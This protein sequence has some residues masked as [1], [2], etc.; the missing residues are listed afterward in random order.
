MDAKVVSV[1]TKTVQAVQLATVNLALLKIEAGAAAVAQAAEA[2][3]LTLT[4]LAAAALTGQITLLTA[5]EKA[6]TIVTNKASAALAKLNITITATTLGIA[7]VGAALIVGALAFKNYVDNMETAAEADPWTKKY[8]EQTRA[9]RD[10][11]SALEELKAAREESNKTDNSEIDNIQRLWSELQ[12]YVDETGNVIAE[13]ERAAEIIELLNKNY[14]M[15]IDYIDGQ[16]QGYQD[17]SSSMDDYIA[18]LRLESQIRNGQDAYDEAVSNYQEYVKK[19]EAL[20]DELDLKEKAFTKAREDGNTEVAMVFGEQANSLKQAIGALDE[21]IDEY[22]EEMSEYESLF[23][24]QMTS[25]GSNPLVDFVSGQMSSASKLYADGMQTIASAQEA[26]TTALSD[27]WKRLEHDFAT[28]AIATESELWA[29]KSALLDKYGNADLED[30]WRYYEELYS[31]QQDYA[32]ESVRLA[33]K[34]AEEQREAAEKAA[35]EQVAAR[36]SEWENIERLNSLGLMNDK[37]AA[38]AR[39]DFVKKYYGDADLTTGKGITDENYQY[40]KKVYDD[41]IDMTKQSI[42]EQE[43]IVDDGL[44]AIIKRYRQAYDDLEQK[45]KAYRD[46]LMAMGGDLFSVEEI[47]NPDGSKKKQYTVNNVD[48]QLRKMREYHAS[49]KKLRADGM[50]DLMLSDLTSMNDEDSMQFAKYLSGMSASEFAKIN[51]L[52]NEKQKLADELANDLYK[53]DAQM[54][55]DSMTDALGDLATSAYAY[56]AQAAEE[57]SNGRHAKDILQSIGQ[58][59]RHRYYSCI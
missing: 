9:I 55:S 7:A 59:K 57:F 35:E 39:A 53:N 37:D 27:G 11:Q 31:Y 45:R 22:S 24:S 23:S 26:A 21:I 34:A 58:Q 6:W 54:I 56:G 51:E 16:I 30:H 15:N 48:E 12:N 49:V 19:R 32:D 29:Q 13:N 25:G 2:G 50:S 20:L 47:E 44:S 17:L 41:N 18:N 40:L 52:Y 46:K 43:K 42:D 28:G 1:I 3:S 33:E 36:Q 14:G 5:V 10:E 4:E 8:D 38:K